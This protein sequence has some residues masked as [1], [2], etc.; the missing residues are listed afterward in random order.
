MPVAKAPWQ[1]IMGMRKAVSLELGLAF[2]RA[3]GRRLD[4]PPS[5]EAYYARHLLKE[6][7]E[8]KRDG[9]SLTKLPIRVPVKVVVKG[10]SGGT[11]L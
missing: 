4:A 2:N 10:A 1:S 9:A 5:Q 3:M 6:F 11:F 8:G 7:I